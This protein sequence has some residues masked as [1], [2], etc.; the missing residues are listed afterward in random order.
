MKWSILI[1][2]VALFA[3][4]LWGHGGL[5]NISFDEVLEFWRNYA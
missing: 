2:M 1:V 4:T 3:L 5:D